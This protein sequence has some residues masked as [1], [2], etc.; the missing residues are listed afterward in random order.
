MLGE[1]L[2]ARGGSITNADALRKAHM[3][4][5]FQTLRLVSA[6]N[7]RKNLLLAQQLQTGGSDPAKVDAT[8]D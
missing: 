1:Q 7:V 8:L 5:I 4:I 6:L 2:I 3:G